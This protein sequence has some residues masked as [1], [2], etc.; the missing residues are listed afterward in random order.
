[1]IGPP[2]SNT[3]AHY[4]LSTVP[5]H[6]DLSTVYQTNAGLFGEAKAEIYVRMV[7]KRI[8][9]KGGAYA[10]NSPATTML[11]SIF[12]PSVV[13]LGLYLAL[14]QKGEQLRNLLKDRKS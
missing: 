13:G 14:V 4:D 11:S 10:Q 8:L 12:V 3:S 1:M 2:P 9:F 6:Y 5:P 7:R